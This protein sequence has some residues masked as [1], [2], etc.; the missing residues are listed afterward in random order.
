[1]KEILHQR[2]CETNS[3]KAHEDH[4][5]LYEA[6]EK[7][8]NRDHTN[9]LLKVLAKA[10][11]KKKKR[12]DSPK[13]PPRSPPHRPPP[14]PPPAGP[15]GSSGSPGSAANKTKHTTKDETSGILKSFITGIENLVDHEADE[16]FFV[17]YSLNSKAFIVFNSRTRIVE[18]NLH[19]RF[20]ESTPNV[21]GSGPDWLFDIDELTRI[22]NYESIVAGTQSNGFIDLKSSNDDGSKPSSDDGKKVDEEP[23]KENECNDQEKEDDVNSTNNVNTVSLTINTTSTNR[24]NDVSENIS[25]ELQFDPNMPALEDVGTFDFSS[26][27]E[28]DGAVADMNNLDTTIQVGPILTTRIHKDHPLDQVIRDLQSATQT[29]KITGRT[30]KGNSYIERSKLDRGYVGRA[31][32]IQVTTSLDFNGLPNEKRAIGSKWVFRNKKDEKRTVIRNKARLVAQGY[33][34]NPKVTHLYAMKRNIRYLKGQPNLGP[35]Y[36]KD[37]PLDLVAY[38]DSDYPGASLDRKSTIRGKAKKSVRLMMEKL[39]GMKL[40]LLLLVES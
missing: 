17:G 35:W 16:G 30:Q 40:V 28:D 32:T 34:V 18:E 36:P 19:I 10:R 15:S 9:E 22:I 20:H 8:M 7:S 24:V 27:D 3:Y 31:S 5:I 13:T 21:V 14:P 11:K 38:A 29:R 2:M 37:S 4:M 23:R 6:L 26:D 25:I 1:M 33:Q 39:F 12:R